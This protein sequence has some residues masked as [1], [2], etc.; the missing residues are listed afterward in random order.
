MIKF[1]LG[2]LFCLFSAV[3]AQKFLPNEHQMRK[4]LV[5]KGLED[6]IS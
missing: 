4:R 2:A 6:M 5:K 3:E 1:I